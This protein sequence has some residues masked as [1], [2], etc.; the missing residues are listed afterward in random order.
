MRLHVASATSP[1]T[2]RSLRHFGDTP[3]LRLPGT[4]C[5]VPRTSLAGSDRRIT[6]VCTRR[7][8]PLDATDKFFREI[9]GVV[10]AFRVVDHSSS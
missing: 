9:P 7:M 2:S 8:Q 10:P 5:L 6:F 3:A 1:G 4:T